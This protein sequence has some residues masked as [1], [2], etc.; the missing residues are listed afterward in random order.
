MRLHSL[1]EAKLTKIIF[2]IVTIVQVDSCVTCALYLLSQAIQEI[3]H[4]SATTV[5]VKPLHLLAI[6]RVVLD[7]LE[8]SRQLL[9]IGSVALLVEPRRLVARQVTHVD[10]RASEE[11]ILGEATATSDFTRGFDLKYFLA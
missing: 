6:F 1:A 3:V 7:W 10:W 8:I 11:Q 2:L 5:R 4:V 9:T